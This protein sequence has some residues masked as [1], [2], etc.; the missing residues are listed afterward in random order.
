VTWGGGLRALIFTLLL[1]G[2]FA[3]LAAWSLYQG[4]IRFNYPSLEDFP[5][6]GVDVSHHQGRIDWAALKGRKVGFAYIK[7]TEGATF[8]DSMFAAN[9]LAASTAGVV[10]GAY[11]F[12]TLC[13]SGAD[14]AANFLAALGPGSAGQLP[15]AVDL[16][17]GGNCSRRP[18][19]AQFETELRVFLERVEQG[20]GCRPLLYVTQ[21]FYLPYVAGSFSGYPWMRNIYREPVLAAGE[22]WTL[23][24][25]ANRGRLPGVRTFIDL[26]V[27]N[28]LAVASK[29]CV[30]ARS[31]RLHRD[32]VS[33]R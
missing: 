7:A 31:A 2:G 32:A 9:W 27:F 10:P 14:Q 33:W 1:L 12:F 15:P 29:V 23:W 24:Q 26:N 3:A 22:R 17:F 28:A 21:D 25:F 5:V 8:R 4:F 18:S 19:K 6:Q 30:A 20:L 13:R 16:E 11:H